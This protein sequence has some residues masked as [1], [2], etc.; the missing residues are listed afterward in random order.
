MDGVSLPTSSVLIS[1]RHDVVVGASAWDHNASGLRAVPSLLEVV[2]ITKGHGEQIALADVGFAANA[3]EVLGLIGPNGA[4]KTTLLEAIAGVL[5][6]D[7]GAGGWRGTALPQARRRAAMF[8]RRD[9]IRQYQEQPVARVLK[10]FAGVYRK[11]AAQV[12]DVIAAVGLAPA[13]DKRVHSLSKGYA[14][15]LMLALGLL[16]PHPL[17]L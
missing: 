12:A 6:A 11:P 3:G 2:G 8:A 4:G 7:S 13:L 1:A 5:P 9:G 10:F 16:A 17:L 14:R 15:R